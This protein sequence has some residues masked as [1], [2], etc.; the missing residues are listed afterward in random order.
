MGISLRLIKEQAVEVS[1]SMIREKIRSHQSVEGLLP[2][3]ILRYIEV[4]GLYSD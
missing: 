2:E 1:S 3:P 4:H